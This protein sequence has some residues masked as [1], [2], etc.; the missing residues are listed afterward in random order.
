MI[1]AV[2]AQIVELSALVQLV[3]IL[4]DELCL[5]DCIRASVR[6]ESEEMTFCSSLDKISYFCSKASDS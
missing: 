2:A 6:V 5:E 1:V 4:I 3:G